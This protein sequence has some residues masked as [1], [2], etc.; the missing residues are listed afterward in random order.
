MYNLIFENKFVNQYDE[1]IIQ[2]LCY[3]YCEANGLEYNDMKTNIY[4][5]VLMNMIFADMAEKGGLEIEKNDAVKLMR[6]LKKYPEPMI[7]KMILA[8]AEKISNESYVQLS[9]VRLAGHLINAINNND[10][11]RV[12]YIGELK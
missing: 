11:N 12:I 7:R 8:S 1:N 9:A 2:N 5:I 6:Q 4:S 3:C 10:L